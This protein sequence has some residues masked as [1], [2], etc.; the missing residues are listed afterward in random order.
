MTV[1]LTIAVL[2]LLAGCGKRTD[3]PRAEPEGGPKPRAKNMLKPDVRDEIAKLVRAGFYD[4]KRLLQ[5]VGEELYAPGELD[6]NDL[7]AAIDEEVAK[8]EA[9][10]KAWPDVTDC[11]RL[12]A[13]FAALN[14][15]G[16]IALH[17]AGFTQSDGYEDFRAALKS[18][19]QRATVL[20][21]CF[22]DSQ[23]VEHAVQGEG[24]HL[25][26]G[27]VR[28]KDEESKGPEIGRIVREELE[29][30]GLKVKW[31]GTFAT[32]MSVPQFVWQRR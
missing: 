31:D 25:A 32:R 6:P 26:F 10:K 17:N 7:A 21:Y 24:L 18:H 14:K 13:A 5:I 4:K 9:E 2:L 19:P 30:A 16:I 22:Y 20:G 8:H 1:R 11:D 3:P 28:P 12:N 15:R 27:P 29:R 23:D